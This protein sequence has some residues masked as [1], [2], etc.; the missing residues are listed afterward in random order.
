[1]L[2]VMWEMWETI[3]LVS[4]GLLATA[5]IIKRIVNAFSPK[6]GKSTCDSC[7][8]AGSCTMEKNTDNCENK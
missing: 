3:I 5:Y 8:M 1:M 7:S 6:K 4:V 2:E